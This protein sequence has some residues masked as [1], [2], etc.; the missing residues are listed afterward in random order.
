MTEKILCSVEILT[1]NS[2]ETLGRCLE[3]VKVFSDI[4][5][6]DGN[7]TDDTPQIA[8]RY[9]ARVI[10]Q[11]DTQEPLVSISDFAR[12]RNKGLRLAREDWFMYIDSD[13]YL[14]P[15]AVEEIRKIVTNPDPS[16]CVWWQPRLYVL[17]GRV[18]HCATTYPNRQIR[19]FHK[20]W[21]QGFIK[22]IHERI[23]PFPEARIGILKGYEYVPLDSL[24]SLRARWARYIDMEV[25]MVRG[26]SLLKKMKF[27]FRYTALFFFYM[28]RYA[29]NL[30]FCRGPRVPFSYEWGRHIFLL[31]FAWKI[32]KTIPGR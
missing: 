20:K 25:E 23:E 17:D 29:R 22:P 21:V 31:Q 6:L 4:I 27:F 3:S 26:V 15:E 16:A 10:P 5:V 9:G 24:D 7:S 13:E 32:V 30:F 2:S 18:I 28:Y 14:S 19:F 8:A 11:Y 12:V 1:R